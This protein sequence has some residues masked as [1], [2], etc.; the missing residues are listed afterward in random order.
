MQFVT[1]SDA[2]PLVVLLERIRVATKSVQVFCSN[3]CDFYGILHHQV[4]E[5]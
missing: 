3:I 4:S 5:C 1:L 2:V